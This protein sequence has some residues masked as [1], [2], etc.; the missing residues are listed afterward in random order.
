MIGTICKRLLREAENIISADSILP[1]F[2]ERSY[3]F[4]GSKIIHN[5]IDDCLDIRFQI[6]VHLLALCLGETVGN[7]QKHFFKLRIIIDS[8]VDLEYDLRNHLTAV[9]SQCI[10][11]L[12]LLLI[13]ADEILSKN[14][15]GKRRNGEHS[16]LWEIDSP[17]IPLW[18]R[19]SDANGDDGFHY[20]T[21]QTL[22]SSAWEY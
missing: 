14:I 11:M 5:G 9:C 19:R 7:V 16:H 1:Q 17:V 4:I 12:V 22:S 10:P 8:A 2:I 15:L 20:E 6:A 21:P 13:Y 18:N 3:P